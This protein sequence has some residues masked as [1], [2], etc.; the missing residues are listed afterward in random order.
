MKRRFFSPQTLFDYFALRNGVQRK[1][2][3]KKQEVVLQWQWTANDQLSAM[4]R[5]ILWILPL[6]CIVVL[7]SLR[8]LQYGDV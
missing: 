4:E 3:S 2:D 1:H 8:W 6:L 5:Y 7:S